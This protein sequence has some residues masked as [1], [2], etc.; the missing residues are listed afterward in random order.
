[1]WCILSRILFSYRKKVLV[2][3]VIIF[4]YIPL[5]LISLTYIFNSFIKVVKC[6]VLLLCQFFFTIYS[7]FLMKYVYL[8]LYNIHRVGDSNKISS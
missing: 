4:I 2:V 8:T 6:P 3:L 1:M 5:D 7:S